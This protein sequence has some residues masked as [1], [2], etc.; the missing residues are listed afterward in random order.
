MSEKIYFKTSYKEP[1]VLFNNVFGVK[2]LSAFEFMLKEEITEKLA[3]S[4]KIYAKNKNLVRKAALVFMCLHSASG[5]RVFSN[6]LDVLKNLTIYEINFIFSW[7]SEVSEKSI[8]HEKMLKKVFSNV[9]R[10][11]Y[12]QI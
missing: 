7:Y 8:R 10:H 12:R 6:V 4:R 1:T 9:K 11:E 2:I 5:E 3:K